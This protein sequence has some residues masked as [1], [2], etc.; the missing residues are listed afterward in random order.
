M[1][2]TNTKRRLMPRFKHPWLYIMLILPVIYFLIFCYGPMYGIVIAFKNYSPVLGV[3]KSPWVGMAQFTRYFQSNYFM[4]TLINTLRLSLYSLVVGIPLPIILAVMFNE[5]KNK[6]FKAISQ[7]ISYVPNFISVVVVVGMVLFFTSP[8]DGVFNTVLSF[9][10][11]HKVDFMGST[12]IFPHVYVWSGVWQ[13]VGWGTLIYT[14]AMSGIPQDQYEAAYLDGATKMQTIWHITLP[15]IKPTIVINSILAA[16]GVLGADFQKI[17]LMQNDMN[18][19]VS[20]VISTYVYKLGV[21]GSDFSFSTAIGLF[22]N[23]VNFV[24][25]IAVNQIA[26]KVGDTSLW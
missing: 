17:L 24:V 20:E 5:L 25:L 1:T 14:A 9:F 3:F 12:S 7:T 16:G 23:I 6:R 18:L 8:V 13:G 2:N 4:E 11:M 21:V 10:H 22:N 19:P 26:K 15:S